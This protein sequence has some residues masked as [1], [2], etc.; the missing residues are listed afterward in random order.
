MCQ[1]VETIKCQDGKLENLCYHQARFNL[2]RKVL[3]GENFGLTLFEEIKVPEAC[4]SGL[5][6]CRVVYASDIEKI[7]FLPHE[8]RKVKSLKLLE[9]S[10]IDYRYKFTNRKKLT[11]LYEK[12]GKCDDI[13]IIN[14]GSI[15]DS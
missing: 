14:N 11:E 8:F 6:R 1:L 13:I 5:F 10:T 3:F 12:R 9:N 15:T 4:Q 2:A 7:E